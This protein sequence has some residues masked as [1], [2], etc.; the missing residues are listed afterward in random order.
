MRRLRMTVVVLGV[1]LAWAP[2]AFADVSSTPAQ[3]PAPSSLAAP[4]PAAGTSAPAS[5]PAPSPAAGTPA[6]ASL[7]PPAPAAGAFAP[8]PARTG[9]AVVA[10]TG[11]ADA[12]WPLAQSVYADPTLRPGAVDDAHARVLC[13][14]VPAPTAAP[15]LRDL[16]DTVAALRG[17]DAP[18][19]ALLDGIARRFALRAVVVVRSDAGHP[20]ARL[21]LADPGA[22]DAAAYSPD[23]PPGPSPTWTATTRSLDRLFGSFTPAPASEAAAAGASPMSAPTLA[24]REAPRNEAPASGP[25]PFYESV[26][27]WGAVGA[28]ALAGGAAY[29]AT[30]DSG[31]S[32]I[33]LE[34]QVPH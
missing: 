29:F 7:P 22:F 27:F 28:A 31:P 12:A 1:V 33:H 34:V 17:D 13:G 10:L 3:P 11:V 5:L 18:T 23:D 4:S 20:T 15:E 14:E 19:R 6:P 9:L 16:S 24:I 26:W 30:R 21:Y 32:T 8:T 25:R 2:A